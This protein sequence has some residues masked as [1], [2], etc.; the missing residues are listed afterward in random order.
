MS[1]DN[2]LR[3]AVVT[4]ASSGLGRAFAR[5]LAS[6]G[7]PVVLVAR[8]RQELELLA[9]ELENQ[10]GRAEV[11][12]ADLATPDGVTAVVAAAG[13]LGGAST[14]S[15]ITPAWEVLAHCSLTRR[16]GSSRRSR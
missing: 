14:S 3:W 11:V 4:G 9:E 2:T 6:R 1:A 5:E 12:V 13:R 10:G 8:R 7:R 16:R 15:S